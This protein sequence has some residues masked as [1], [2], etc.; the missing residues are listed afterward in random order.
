MF[1]LKISIEILS[2]VDANTD[3]KTPSTSA[4]KQEIVF[5]SIS[6]LMQISLTNE[7]A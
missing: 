7:E 6:M 3:V 5:K 1:A 2:F 4:T